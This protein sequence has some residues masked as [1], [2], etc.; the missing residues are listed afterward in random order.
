MRK[1]TKIRLQS[2]VALVLIPIVTTLWVPSLLVMRVAKGF[3]VGADQALGEAWS[4]LA[5][6]VR[7]IRLC[8][9]S[10]WHGSTA[11]ALQ[12]VIGRREGERPK[13]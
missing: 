5:L 3:L 6:S 8:S 11:K 2:A 12:K 4:E 10:L 13:P 1:K 9:L 7:F